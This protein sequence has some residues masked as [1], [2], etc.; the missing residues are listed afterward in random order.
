MESDCVRERCQPGPRSQS[1][2]GGIIREG[3]LSW[4]TPLSGRGAC[5]TRVVFCGKLDAGTF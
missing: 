2:F 5:E 3:L 1:V 4:P